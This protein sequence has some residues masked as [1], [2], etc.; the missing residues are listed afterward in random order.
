VLLGFPGFGRRLELALSGELGDEVDVAICD[1]LEEV[2]EVRAGY[3]GVDQVLQRL[4]AILRLHAHPDGHYAD[5]VSPKLLENVGAIAS[6]HES[7]KGARMVDV[8]AMSRP[9]Q[10]P[11][12]FIIISFIY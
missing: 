4:V 5:D 10:C 9:E 8:I 2:P 3:A 6:V 11:G 12:D 1:F 7:S